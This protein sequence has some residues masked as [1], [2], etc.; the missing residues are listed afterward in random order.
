METKTCMCG[1]VFKAK[2]DR[3][4]FCSRRCQ[5]N[6]NM[7]SRM[8]TKARARYRKWLEEHKSMKSIEELNTKALAAG[9]SYGVYVALKGV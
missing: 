5:S 7:E 4:L 6:Y 9:M 1:K 3:H 2:S 8:E